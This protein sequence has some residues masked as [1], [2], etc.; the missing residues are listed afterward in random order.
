M[1]TGDKHPNVI[2]INTTKDPKANFILNLAR[3]MKICSTADLARFQV[4]KKQVAANGVGSLKNLVDRD[5]KIMRYACDNALGDNSYTAMSKEFMTFDA[6][7]PTLVTS[8]R[9]AGDEN[10]RRMGEVL[11]QLLF[12]SGEPD[13][14]QMDFF[15]NTVGKILAFERL[16]DS[17]YFDRLYAFI[18]TQGGMKENLASPTG[19]AIGANLVASPYDLSVGYTAAG[20]PDSPSVA[21]TAALATAPATTA[22]A[23]T[24]PATTAPATT[25][26][27]SL[28]ATPAK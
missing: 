2:S 10:R 4:L 18:R 7:S 6:I 25:A 15:N 9:L 3:S 24:A 28:T 20:G 26:T 16:E 17:N 12:L 8:L 1:N 22:P 23:T 19:Y 11:L 21:A 5:Y 14:K 13:Q 27:A